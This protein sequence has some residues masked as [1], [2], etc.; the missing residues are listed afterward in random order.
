MM[1][2]TEVNKSLQNTTNGGAFL[3]QFEIIM[4]RVLFILFYFFEAI[5]S[6]Q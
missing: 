5:I 1:I 3:V 2:R 4:V 6:L